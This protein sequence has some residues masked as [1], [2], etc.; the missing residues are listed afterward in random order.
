M[1]LKQTEITM[2]QRLYSVTKDERNSLSNISR[3]S[4]TLHIPG[5]GCDI[6][7]GCGTYSRPGS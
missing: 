7:F 5:E 1:Q 3:T 4:Y 6:S 2:V